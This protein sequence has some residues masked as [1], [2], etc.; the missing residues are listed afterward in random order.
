L[1][2]PG[3]RRRGVSLGTVLRTKIALT[4]GLWCAP[5]LLV[6]AGWFARLG[7]PAPQ[8][9]VFVRLLGAAYLAL[10]AG[11]V[12]GLRGMHA[13]RPPADAVVMGIVSNGAACVLLVAYGLAGAYAEWGSFARGY[14]WASA[15]ATGLITIALVARRPSRGVAIN[16]ESRGDAERFSA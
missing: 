14:M 15:L 1:T 6:P 9:M 16:A 13:G 11:Y 7:F 12:R 8:P 5:L 10:L 3:A 2:V 4:A